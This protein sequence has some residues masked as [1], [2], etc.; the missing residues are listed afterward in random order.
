MI[1]VPSL[2][3]QSAFIVRL[4][5]V[6]VGIFL[7]RRCKRDEKVVPSD[8]LHPPGQHPCGSPMPPEYGEPEK[9]QNEM[10]PGMQEMYTAP[11]AQELP[12][13]ADARLK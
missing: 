3:K 11:E 7:W 1:L 10:H 6:V 4:T 8:F 2:S 9:Q 5:I 12:A 13:G